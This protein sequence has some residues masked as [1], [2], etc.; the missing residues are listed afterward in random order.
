MIDLGRTSKEAVF[1]ILRYDPSIGLV[2]VRKKGIT[3]TRHDT[4][5]PD[6]V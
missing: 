6:H 3:K 5:P 1:A 4:R 2:G